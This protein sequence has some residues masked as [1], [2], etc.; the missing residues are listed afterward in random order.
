MNI[1]KSPYEAC[2]D[3]STAILTTP[4]QIDSG[5]RSKRVL[6][7]SLVVPLLLAIPINS[8]SIPLSALFGSRV[9]RE[10]TE[11]GPSGAGCVVRTCFHLHRKALDWMEMFKRAPKEG[12]SLG[13]K[14]DPAR[15][16]SRARIKVEI[17]GDN[18][19]GDGP[20]R[21][22]AEGLEWLGAVIGEGECM[23]SFE[24]FPFDLV[25]C[26]PGRA[27]LS[28]GRAYHL[29]SLAVGLARV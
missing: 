27:A 7:P 10:E 13:D 3:T 25:P 4:R 23:T 9:T 5:D 15:V 18:P 28:N 17:R 26:R 1:A 11:Q 16:T 20:L 8:K 14:R 12:R 6:A 24:F 22:M 21:G 19:G 29:R 2:P